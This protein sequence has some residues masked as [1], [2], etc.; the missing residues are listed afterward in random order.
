MG[1]LQRLTYKKKLSTSYTC[2]LSLLNNAIVL[3]KP[4]ERKKSSKDKNKVFTLEFYAKMSQCSV[5]D[6]SDSLEFCT[7]LHFHSALLMFIRNPEYC[8]LAIVN[9]FELRNVTTNVGVTLRCD[10]L[11]EKRLWLKD[12]RTHIRDHKIKASD[13]SSRSILG[14]FRGSPHCDRTI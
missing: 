9:G 10:S 5:T 13:G 11:E 14:T 1:E 4:K 6:L 7:Q 3:A 8:F 12:L 2:S